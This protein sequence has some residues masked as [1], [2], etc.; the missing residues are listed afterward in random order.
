MSISMD[1]EN[2]FGKIQH[3]FMIKNSKK[4]G[5]EGS[6]FTIIEA[7]F[8]KPTATVRCSGEKLKA[9]L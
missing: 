3:P 1:A 9:F 7:T 4:V 8:D 2:A 5:T 6:C